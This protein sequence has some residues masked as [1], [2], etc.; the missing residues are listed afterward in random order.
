[1]ICDIIEW[2]KRFVVLIWHIS[3]GFC[4]AKGLQ[5]SD[6]G[7]TCGNFQDDPRSCEPGCFCPDGYALHENGTCVNPESG[8]QCVEGGRFYDIGQIS[9]SDCSR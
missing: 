4:K 7:T 9:P 6:C 2:F 8:C 5:Y 3:T 1:M